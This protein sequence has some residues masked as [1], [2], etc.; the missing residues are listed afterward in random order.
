[1]ATTGFLAPK[2]WHTLMTLIT[3]VYLGEISPLGSL[4]LR[5]KC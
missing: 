5:R 1:M 4:E 3:M 2:S